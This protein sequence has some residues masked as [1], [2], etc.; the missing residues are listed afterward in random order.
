MY[1]CFTRGNHK[2]RDIL[3]GRLLNLHS[4]NIWKYS[5]RW[6]SPVSGNVAPFR[7]VIFYILWLQYLW[8]RDEDVKSLPKKRVSTSSSLESIHLYHSPRCHLPRAKFFHARLLVPINKS[9]Q[10]RCVQ[11]FGRVYNPA[12]EWKHAFSSL[13]YPRLYYNYCGHCFTSAKFPTVDSLTQNYSLFTQNVL[14]RLPQAESLHT[15]CV[16][17]PQ[18]VFEH[19]VHL[20]M[21]P[22]EGYKTNHANWNKA[23]VFHYRK[24]QQLWCNSAAEIK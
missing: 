20:I 17:D 14:R 19:S 23:R 15:K 13:Q 1:G 4:Y 2:K 8:Q 11:R 16:D 5:S 18:R 9:S 24:C 10:R 12:S 22:F 21:Q 6:C 7:S 3:R